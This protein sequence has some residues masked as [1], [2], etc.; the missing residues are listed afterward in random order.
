MSFGDIA[1]QAILECCLQRVAK[2]HKEIDWVAALIIELDRFVDDL[3][4]GSNERAVLDRLRGQ[5]VEDWQTTGTLA[6]IF[7][8]GGFKLKVVACSGDKDGPMVSIKLTVNIS[9]R[10]RGQATGPE[11]TIQ[12]LG[13]LDTAVLTRRIV[14]SVT[15]GI[16][17]PVGYICPLTT[18]LR[19]LVQQLGKLKQHSTDKKDKW[20]DPLSKDEMAPWLE[21]F[22]KMV[23]A[24]AIEFSRSCKP[25]DVDTAKDAILVA[26]MDRSDAAKAFAAYLRYILYSGQIHVGLLTARSKLNSAGGQSTP[27]SEMDIHTLGA[28]GAR[29]I[30][31][32]MMEITPRIRKVYMLGDSKTVLQALKMGA[33]PF[34]EWFA[35]RVGE[36]WDCMRDIPKDV[37]IIWGWVRSEDNAA[38]IASRT[39]ANP[40]DLMEGSVWQDGPAFLKLPEDQWPIDTKLMEESTDILREELRRQYKHQAFLQ[41]SNTGHE[42]GCMPA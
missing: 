30:N 19:W 33:T 35:N 37:E 9:K 31:A 14:L 29:T 23:Q 20:D 34:S 11:L 36:V 40:S 10:R 26:F 38:D 17:D 27:R 21:L 32:A 2:H 7:A 15:M 1:A 4:S 24:G 12:T 16:Y 41:Q 3:P 13:D 25:E 6:E 39:N 42:Q 22:R 8:K 18:R 28:R 5:I